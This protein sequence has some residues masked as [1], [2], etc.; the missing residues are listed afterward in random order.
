[1]KAGGRWGFVD[2]TGNFVIPV[3]FDFVYSFSGGRALV[4]L[5]DRWGIIDQRGDWT[6]PPRPLQR[7]LPMTDGAV[8]VRE[9]GENRF[10]D[11][12]GN[13][14][15]ISFDEA[16]QFSEGLAAVRRGDKWGYVDRAGGQALAFQY[17]DASTFSG[18]LA[19]VTKDGKS[20]FIDKAG[21][22]IFEV[23]NRTVIGSFSDGFATYQPDKGPVGYVDSKGRVVIEPKF[24]YAG[25]FSE[26]LAKISPQ[27]TTRW[28]FVNR[29]GEVVVSPIYDDAYAFSNGLAS[30]K[31]NGRWGYIDKLGKVAIPFRFDEAYEF[32]C[33]GAWV[34]LDGKIGHIDRKGN[35]LIRPVEP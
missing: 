15:N 8:L 32:E 34:R 5:E 4:E 14:L 7:V 1:M 10:L 28:G 16:R 29:K 31:R 2:R 17:E 33:G 12:N 9:N 27:G 24:H 26:G 20:F 19:E 3:Q 13:S 11:D 21:E 18:G 35:F 23:P 30:V 25:D 22:K 6:M